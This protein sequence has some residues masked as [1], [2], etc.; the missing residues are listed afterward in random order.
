MPAV[1]FE[2]GTF[3]PVFSCGVMD[4]LL[5]EDIMFPY[6]IG[7]SAGSADAA[8]YI[9]RQRGRNLKSLELYRNDKRYLSRR[10]YFKEGS[11]FGVQ[12]VFRD[13]PNIHIP[14]DMETFQAYEG[15]FIIVTT[16]AETG[17][18]EYFTQKDVDED[19]EVFH[20]TCALPLILPPA[21]IHEREYFDGGLSNPIPID[22]VLEDG[23]DKVLIVLTRT[24]DYKKACHKKDIVAARQLEKKYPQIAR[25]I[26]NRHK[27]YNH[28]LK[29]CRQLE[30][31]GR[32][33]VIRP[34]TPLVSLEKNVEVL[35]ESWQSG[36]DKAMERMDEIK[37]LFQ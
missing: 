33:V 22:K 17:K 29:I 19:F 25:A 9:S 35:R 5:D 1:L 10:N 37:A 4:A 24:Q 6:C 26:V 21:T 16:D 11:I 8:S 15:Q 31:Q 23:N 36:Y 14:F 32:A 12:F 2:G 34:D 27:K 3:R 18:V 7:V 13:I 30:E 28:S 20:A